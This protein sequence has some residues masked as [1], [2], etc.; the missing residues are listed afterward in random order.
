MKE[1][2]FSLALEQFVFSVR[3][4]I[5]MNSNLPIEQ[6]PQMLNRFFSGALHP[7]IHTG[8][9]AEFGLPGLLVEGS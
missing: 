9:G 7:F 5:G 2:G 4:N 8:C 1:N 6:Q 3:A